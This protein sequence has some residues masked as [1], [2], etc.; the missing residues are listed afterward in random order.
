MLSSPPQLYKPDELLCAVF[1]AHA[2]NEVLKNVNVALAP[3]PNLKMQVVHDP[4]KSRMDGASVVVIDTL[5][6]R[7]YVMVL[8]KLRFEAHNVNMSPTGA[9]QYQL[10]NGSALQSLRFAVEVQIPDLLRKHLITTPVFG[11]HWKTLKCEKKV[12]VAPTTVGSPAEFMTRV[13]KQLNI[14]PIQIIGQEA[15]AAGRVAVPNAEKLILLHGKLDAAAK[16]LELSV[17]TQDMFFTD[18]VMRH[19]AVVFK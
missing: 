2:S 4:D 17:H 7:S 14:S 5:Q 16:K 8:L 9:I 10:G 1:I 6:P 15:I 12:L 11:E 13:E 18:I 3:P 19:L